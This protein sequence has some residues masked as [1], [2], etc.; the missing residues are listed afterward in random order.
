MMV[1]E[2]VIYCLREQLSVSVNACAAW[3]ARQSDEG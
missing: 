3:H 2:V 1:I